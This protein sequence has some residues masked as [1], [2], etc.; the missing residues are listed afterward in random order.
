MTHNGMTTLAA[1]GPLDD[2]TLDDATLRVCDVGH[3]AIAWSDWAAVRCPICARV[4]TLSGTLVD[5]HTALMDGAQEEADIELANS[6]A[7]EREMRDAMLEARRSLE[8]LSNDDLDPMTARK[9]IEQAYKI[10]DD[11]L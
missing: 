4:G 3:I 9:Y 2:N 11:A 6:E 1:C 8:G 5:A 10:L 7:T